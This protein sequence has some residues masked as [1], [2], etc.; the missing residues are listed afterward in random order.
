MLSRVT[1]RRMPGLSIEPLGP[2][3]TPVHSEA[4]ARAVAAHVSADAITR[5]VAAMVSN[6]NGIKR[7]L[8]TTPRIAW[9]IY[10][11]TVVPPASGHG[12]ALPPDMA[13]GA[14][15]QILTLVDDEMLRLGG[16]FAC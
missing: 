4:Q 8:P 15:F 16:N 6:P 9:V 12:P 2:G 7:G 5:V 11:D 13:P 3:Q 14:T 10:H 1:T